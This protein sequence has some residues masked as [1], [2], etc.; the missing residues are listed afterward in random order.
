MATS[1]TVTDVTN[2]SKLVDTGK[3]NLGVY[4]PSKAVKLTFND[5]DDFSPAWSPNGESI[6][7][8]SDR[9][10]EHDIYLLDVDTEELPTNLTEEIVWP[11]ERTGSNEYDPTW[12]N[13]GKSIL[14]TSYGG[15]DEDI[16]RIGEDGSGLT[17]LTENHQPGNDRYGSSSPDGEYILFQSDREGNHDIFL[18]GSDGSLPVNLTRTPHANETNPTWVTGG[19][20]G[21][22]LH[23]TF[24][25]APS[26]EGLPV[27]AVKRDIFLASPDFDAYLDSHKI[28]LKTLYPVTQSREIDA[29]S[30]AV[31]LSG[32]YLLYGG[33]VESVP[34]EPSEPEVQKAESQSKSGR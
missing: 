25:I 31:S 33:Y 7:F 14:F 28:P 34:E 10:G 5:A 32:N 21:G 1:D 17:N 22:D 23:F 18:M 9:S 26:A 30:A 15:S 19:D 3:I 29:Y 8:V 2:D 13:D 27:T 12:S 6:A 16:W 20:F 4:G 11:D 24:Q